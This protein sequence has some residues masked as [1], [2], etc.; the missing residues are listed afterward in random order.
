MQKGSI[1]IYMYLILFCIIYC[2]VSSK[3]FFLLIFYLYNYLLQLPYE[4]FHLTFTLSI[5]YVEQKTN[6]AIQ[7]GGEV[8]GTDTSLTQNL[9]YFLHHDRDRS[10]KVTQVSI[11]PFSLI[12]ICVE[13]HSIIWSMYWGMLRLRE[14]DTPTWQPSIRIHAIKKISY[15]SKTINLRWKF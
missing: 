2:F 3:H 14:D 15:N 12:I 7:H 8:E 9:P 13:P 5:F 6:D 10:G 1:K 11:L 4:F